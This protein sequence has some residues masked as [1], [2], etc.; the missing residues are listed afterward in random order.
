METEANSPEPGDEKN[1]PPSLAETCIRELVG[2]ASFGHV[3]CVLKPVLRYE[4]FLKV[5]TITLKFTMV[6]NFNIRN[7]AIFMTYLDPDHKVC[8]KPGLG[9]RQLIQI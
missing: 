5:I 2:R 8:T 7:I 1:S 9:S 3:R 6:V 4:K